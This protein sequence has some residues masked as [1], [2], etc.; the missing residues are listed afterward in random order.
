MDFETG[1]TKLIEKAKADY[2]SW[3]GHQAHLPHVAAMIQEYNDSF[4]IEEGSKFIKIVSRNSVHC[5]I[6]KGN[7]GKFRM[8]DILKAASWKAPA[9]NFAR[10]N[11]IDGTFD[12]IRWTGAL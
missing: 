3:A 5:F 8:G 10:G 4:R 2:L 11:V 12:R 9:K 6:A 1:I 7:I